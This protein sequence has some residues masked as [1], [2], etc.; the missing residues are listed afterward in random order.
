[1]QHQ[2]TDQKQG[3]MCSA[4]WGG[5]IQK[6]GW[7]LPRMLNQPEPNILFDFDHEPT[8]TTS[9]VTLEEFSANEID[10]A[11]HSLTRQQDSTRRQQN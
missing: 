9:D 5:A 7:T 10:K 8:A 6:M 4:I 3:R 11:I 1:M 2:S